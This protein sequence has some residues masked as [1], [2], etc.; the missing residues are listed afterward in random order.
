L[1][2]F[3]ITMS[4]QRKTGDLK[5]NNISSKLL[6]A[7]LS[8]INIEKFRDLS[9]YRKERYDIGGQITIPMLRTITNKFSPEVIFTVTLPGQGI[10]SLEALGECENL[11]VLNMSKN[12]IENVGALK[13]LKKLRIVDLSE[14]CITTIDPLH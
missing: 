10:A 7:N 4:K 12:N 9:Q 8:D 14:N 1:K 6:G 2:L 11:M 3:I 13:K 5:D